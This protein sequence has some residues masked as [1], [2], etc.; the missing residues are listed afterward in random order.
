MDEFTLYGFFRNQLRCLNAFIYWA[1]AVQ[2][3]F[4]VPMPAALQDLALGLAVAVGAG[5]LF[6]VALLF[7]KMMCVA[8]GT[9]GPYSASLIY[10]LDHKLNPLLDWPYRRFWGPDS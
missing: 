4:H 7:H 6:W 5:C 9:G 2:I 10:L 3:A 1:L 8:Q